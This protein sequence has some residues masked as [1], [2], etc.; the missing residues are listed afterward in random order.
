M[1]CLHRTV[2]RR[3]TGLR[4]TFNWW[5]AATVDFLSSARA[6]G[7]ALGL[8]QSGLRVESR[9]S[10]NTFPF[11]A[12]FMVVAHRKA[13]LRFCRWWSK[14]GA[15]NAHRRFG[16]LRSRWQSRSI[17]PTLARLPFRE[18]LRRRPGSLALHLRYKNIR[19]DTHH[20]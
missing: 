14:R 6:S 9:R 19:P 13:L 18:T 11:V 3:R 7:S 4:Y 17:F 5:R 10:K 2:R 15:D 12:R 20:S 16:G 1:D 8:G